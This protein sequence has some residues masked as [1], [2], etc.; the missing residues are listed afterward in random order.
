MIIDSHTHLFPEEVRKNRQSFCRRDEGFRLIYESDRA[1]MASPEELL[2]SMDR[3]GVDR[4]VICGFPWKDPGICRLG[5]DYL[6][7]CSFRNPS[8][9]IPYACLPMVPRRLAERELETALSR[10][11]QGIGEL[12]FYRTE[13]SSLEIQ[14]LSSILKPLSGERVPLLLHVSEPVGHEYPGKSP[15]GL[16][17]IYQLLAALS[18]VTVILA[19][20][21]GGFFFY[22]LMPEVARLTRNVLYDTAASPY[23]YRPQIYSLAVKIVGPERVLFGS[24]Y[25]LIAP[26]R[27]FKELA[28]SG[29][30]TRVQ[31]KIK[32]RNAWQFLPGRAK[33]GSKPRDGV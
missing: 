10:G 21:G 25:P 19:H 17:P 14:R 30:S 2:Q 8:R 18:G 20:W 13:I 1:R 6:I 24:D 31:A 5:N 33:S 27:Y 22:E 15:G 26:A 32:G 23:L 4:S 3:D 7:D 29:L 28:Q 11:I 16:K 12:A 9:L